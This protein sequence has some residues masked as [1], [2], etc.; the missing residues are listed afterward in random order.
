MLKSIGVPHSMIIYS[1]HNSSMLS[2]IILLCH[3]LLII[4]CL[5]NCSTQYTELEALLNDRYGHDGMI[6][7]SM[8]LSVSLRTIFPDIVFV[9]L[10]KVG[11]IFVLSITSAVHAYILMYIRNCRRRASCLSV[12]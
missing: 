7:L 5:I 1:M 8:G 4:F 2:H 10:A 12:K 11:N 3:T 6:D 9:T